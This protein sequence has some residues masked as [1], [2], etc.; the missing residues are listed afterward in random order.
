MPSPHKR[1]REKLRG[2]VHR[3]AVGEGDVRSRLLAAHWLLSQLTARDLPPECLAVYKQ[4]MRDLTKKGPE[5]GPAGEV[6]KPACQ[7]TMSR[8]R[9][10]T[11]RDIAERIYALNTDLE[12]LTSK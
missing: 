8:I 2:A 7:H 4:I 5:L 1:A 9:N 6:W 10:A 12:H 11:G 3:L